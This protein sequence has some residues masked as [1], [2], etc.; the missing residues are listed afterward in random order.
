MIRSRILGALPTIATRARDVLDAVAGR[1]TVGER[2]CVRALLDEG[3]RYRA[4][5]AKTVAAL[6]AEI[7]DAR[8]LLGPNPPGLG[9]GVRA[10]RKALDASRSD[11]REA[12]S[13][14][15][16]RGLRETRAILWSERWKALARRLRGEIDTIGNL[17]KMAEAE[18]DEARAQVVRER[19]LRI[20]AEG[21]A[22]DAAEEAQR[23]RANG[24]KWFEDFE[25]ASVER[26]AACRETAAWKL[27]AA[28][29]KR[30]A[31]A[32]RPSAADVEEAKRWATVG[33][34]PRLATLILRLVG[35]RV[36]S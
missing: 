10:M 19:S 15:T 31:E 9:E 28:D 3:A 7:A 18:R 30:E 1:P 8:A 26:D 33:M 5:V 14:A 12:E 21:E 13:I 32:L 27:A 23:E 36:T 16:A 2:E 11:M 29:A 35:I 17:C 20:A 6:A 34:D 25:Q 24:A 22:V 4:D